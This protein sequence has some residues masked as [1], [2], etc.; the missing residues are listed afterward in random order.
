M[1]TI[2]YRNGL[3]VKVDPQLSQ[4]VCEFISKH[5]AGMKGCVQAT[6]TKDQ[7][8]LIRVEDVIHIEP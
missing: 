5:G 6:D 7:I 2:Y 8:T 4:A 3:T 1:P